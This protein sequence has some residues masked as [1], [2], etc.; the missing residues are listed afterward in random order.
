M[1]WTAE[2][3]QTA[4]VVISGFG[5]A[6]SKEAAEAV[7]EAVGRKVTRHALERALKRNAHVVPA[8]GEAEEKEPETLRSVRDPYDAALEAV[9]NA[10]YDSAGTHNGLAD[11]LPKLPTTPRPQRLLIL[12]D[13]HAPVQDQAAIDLICLVAT[14][15]KP[16]ILI[17][18]GDLLDADSM[19]SYRRKPDGLTLK[20]EVEGANAAL[21]QLDA[22]KIKRKV[23]TLGNHEARIQNRI[24]DK[25]PELHGL[26]TVPSLLRLKE[27]GWEWCEY[28]DHVTIGKVVYTHEQGAC[29][30]RA[31]VQA[32]DA[33][34]RSVVIGHTH[35][36]AMDFSGT[37]H[38]GNRVGAMFGGLLDM[39]RV[40]YLHKA[41]LRHWQ[42]GF[43]T[44]IMLEG[45]ETFLRPH[46]I[47]KVDGHYTCEVDGVVYSNA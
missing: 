1:R 45:G 14:T 24:L 3:I 28:T 2:E 30:A 43:G 7:S 41:Q 27:R 17:Q 46:P 6:R 44:G 13:I 20:H 18:L 39:S 36:M 12:P 47:L 11:W 29:G 21:D 35:R 22:L 4:R 38:D 8:S 23:L 32:K 15:W 5:G 42:L 16:D 31:H 9:A 10:R 19:S 37:V 34:G 25:I 26:V 40:T 33:V